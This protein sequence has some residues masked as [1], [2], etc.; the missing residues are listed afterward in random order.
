[1]IEPYK[2]PRPHKTLAWLLDEGHVLTEDGAEDF[3]ENALAQDVQVWATSDRLRE[4]TRD[5]HGSACLWR[6]VAIG[7]HPRRDASSW[8]VRGL[9][10]DTPDDPR[11]ALE[12]MMKWRDW[13]ESYGAAPAGSLGGSGLSLVKASLRRNLWT[14]TGDS[15]P[16][17]F[18]LGGRQETRYPAPSHVRGNLVHSDI[19]AAYANTLGGLLYG[20]RWQKYPWRDFWRTRHEKTPGLLIYVRAVVDVPELAE[21]FPQLHPGGRGPLIRRPKKTPTIAD[22]LF[23]NVTE[24][25]FPSGRRIQGVWTMDEL[26]GAEAA[27]CTVKKVLDVWIHEANERPFET[28]LER[29]HE[30]RDM[31]GFASR[32]AKATGNATWGQFAIA[33][34][35]RMAVAKGRSEKLPLRGS[36]PSQRAFDLAESIAGRVRVNL[37]RGMLAVGRELLCAH[38]DGLWSSA[39]AGVIGWR[40]TDYADEMRLFDAQHYAVRSGAGEW[41]YVVAGVLDP[42]KWFEA[43]WERTRQPAAVRMLS[44]D[45]GVT[46]D[47]L[48]DHELRDLAAA[49]EADEHRLAFSRVE[50]RTRRRKVRLDWS[51]ATLEE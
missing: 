10:L 42:E 1:M 51:R 43:A 21:T 12:G 22:S 49:V 37:Y 35:Q 45:M 30:G 40:Q 33:N 44:C 9:A 34:G 18:T 27:G 3:L 15:P 23:W 20:G 17:R 19:Q 47:R 8:P 48:S 29:V 50:T 46:L 13:L 24:D 7:W 26:E 32:L 16:I 5:G 36:N 6:Y 4:L 38:T 31:R 14:N 25:R 41:R 39:G 28:W 2:K 11:E